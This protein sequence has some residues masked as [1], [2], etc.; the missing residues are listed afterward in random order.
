MGTVISGLRSSASA[1][2]ALSSALDGVLDKLQ[3]M[4]S[5]ALFGGGNS[6]IFGGGSN[7]FLGGLLNCIGGIGGGGTGSVASGAPGLVMSPFHHS[8]GVVGQT[9]VPTRSV[10]SSLFQ[11]APRY[12]QGGVAGL[13]GDEVPAILQKGEMIIPRHTTTQRMSASPNVTVPPAQ[14]QVNVTGGDGNAEV[15]QRQEGGVNVIDVVLGE[16][17]KAIAQGGMDSV[18]AGR[19]NARPSIR[20][21]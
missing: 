8:G 14:I 13:K 3:Q 19:Y 16:V 21:R 11:N 2:D 12:H 9:A 17:R 7:G 4:A 1:S 5:N 15:T 10:A 18:M 6:G 20:R